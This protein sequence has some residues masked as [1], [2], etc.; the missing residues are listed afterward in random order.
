M[1]HA[2]PEHSHKPGN[3]WPTFEQS[4][5]KQYI[6]WKYHRHWW[7]LSAVSWTW[8]I[9]RKVPPERAG[10]LTGW[11]PWRMEVSPFRCHTKRGNSLSRAKRWNPAPARDDAIVHRWLILLTFV[12]ICFLNLSIPCCS[13]TFRCEFGEEKKSVLL[14]GRILNIKA[15]K[16]KRFLIFRVKK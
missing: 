14:C 16:T 6:F 3:I 2:L 7:Q 8:L 1:C 11:L 12:F 13:G 4:W 10:L 5:I 9:C 15:Q